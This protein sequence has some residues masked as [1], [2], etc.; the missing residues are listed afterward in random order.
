VEPPPSTT[1][2]SA[3]PAPCSHPRSSL[4]PVRPHRLRRI[5]SLCSLGK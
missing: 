1:P 3:F 5:R 2:S 4:L